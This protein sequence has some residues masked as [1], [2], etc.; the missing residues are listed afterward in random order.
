MGLKDKIKEYKAKKKKTKAE[1]LKGYEDEI[2]EMLE[3]NIPLKKQIEFILEEGILQ[4][5]DI[6]EYIKILKKYFGYVG[7]YDKK[8][9]NIVKN[10]VKKTF[11]QAKKNLKND[12]VEMLS[13]DVDILDFID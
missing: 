6:M 1:I 12:P 10:E 7:R 13:K 8:N 4:K 9:K 11:Q 2:K 5:L 3:L